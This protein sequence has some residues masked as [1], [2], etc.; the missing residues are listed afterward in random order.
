MYMTWCMN[1]YQKTWIW[2]MICIYKYKIT[3]IIYIYIDR[4][5]YIHNVV[6]IYRIYIHII[7]FWNH[8]STN[9]PLNFNQ[10]KKTSSPTYPGV[11]ENPING[12]FPPKERLGEVAGLQ[13]II[14]TQ[15]V[16][17]KP[18][19]SFSDWKGFHPS[20]PKTK[21]KEQKSGKMFKIFPG[22][23]GSLRSSAKFHRV[24][25]GMV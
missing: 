1:S 5:N 8:T 21:T 3:H 16:H 17:L 7:Y 14:E 15:A 4:Y 6:H 11:A 22:E 13:E 10:Q 20:P 12:V 9:L 24:H 19:S 18:R 23:H 25:R 2:Y